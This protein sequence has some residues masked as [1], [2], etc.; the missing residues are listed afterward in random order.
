MALHAARD[1]NSPQQPWQDAFMAHLRQPS[2]SLY[3]RW[4]PVAVGCYPLFILGLA[5]FLL[6]L[7]CCQTAP[8]EYHGATVVLRDAGPLDGDSG[9]IATWLK[10]D[11]VLRAALINTKWPDLTQG[12]ASPDQNRLVTE[13]RERLTITT[14][15][16]PDE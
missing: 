8:P 7:L 14:L 11:A 13:L 4:L 16:Q 2:R 3:A 1:S 9:E 12:S 5:T 15:S 6:G 10:S